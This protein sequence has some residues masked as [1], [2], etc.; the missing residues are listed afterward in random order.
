MTLSP[1]QTC[2]QFSGW[3]H[4][5]E[6]CGHCTRPRKNKVR[7]VLSA[8]M[9]A[10]FLIA[11]K[12]SA[13]LAE[14]AEAVRATRPCWLRQDQ[15]VPPTGAGKPRQ[16]ESVKADPAGLGSATEGRT[17]RSAEDYAH[18]TQEALQSRRTSPLWPVRGGR[19]WRD[20][21][22]W[23]GGQP[24][25]PR[26]SAARYTGASRPGQFRRTARGRSGPGVR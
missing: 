20:A 1:G 13:P 25:V 7:N 3:E 23:R 17:A 16:G 11:G 26:R 14:P 4:S 2:G 8:L 24:E 19:R 22:R 12:R 6:A 15:S 9:L 10:A 5:A 18:V 21:G